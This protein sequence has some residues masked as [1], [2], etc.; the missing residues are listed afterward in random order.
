[1]RW[2]RDEKAKKASEGDDVEYVILDFGGKMQRVLINFYQLMMLQFIYLVILN[3]HDK[4]IKC[5]INSPRIRY[6]VFSFG[7]NIKVSNTL[8]TPCLTQ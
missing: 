8:S 1:L 5:L 6:G 4:Q 3:N 7:T 2:V